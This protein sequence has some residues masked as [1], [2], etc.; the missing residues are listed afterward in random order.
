M[1]GPLAVIPVGKDLNHVQESVLKTEN[2]FQMINVWVSQQKN[3]HVICMLVQVGQN[4]QIGPNG[5]SLVAKCGDQN[6][7]TASIETK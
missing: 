3:K 6:L 7:E 2:M 4:G 1:V 5:L